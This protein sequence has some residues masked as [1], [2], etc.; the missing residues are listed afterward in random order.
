MD[1]VAFTRNTLRDFVSHLAFRIADDN[2]IVCDQKSVGD[3]TFCAER[4]TGAGSA[5]N[6]TV[7]IFQLFRCKGSFEGTSSA[8]RNA[9]APAGSQ[10]GTA[11]SYAFGRY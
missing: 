11:H 5:E 8:I 3:F 2:I 1:R 4:F 6:Q 10:G 9:P 7:G